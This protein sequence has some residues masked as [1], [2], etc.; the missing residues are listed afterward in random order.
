MEVQNCATIKRVKKQ[1]KWHQPYLPEGVDQQQQV[2][3][4]E[5]TPPHGEGVD[6]QQQATDD[7]S[8][9]PRVKKVTVKESKN[10]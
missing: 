8:M 10:R 6:Q 9:P 3:D 7:E 5:S 1:D 2:T 4:G